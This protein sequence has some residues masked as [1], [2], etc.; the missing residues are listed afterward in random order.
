M[1]RATGRTPPFGDLR[2]QWRKMHCAVLNPYSSDTCPYSTEDCGLAFL[3]AVERSVD[4]ASPVGY[5]R[6]V[7]RSM[8]LDR[9]DNK[10][11]ERERDTTPRPSYEGPVGLHPAEGQ[12]L[13]GADRGPVR[14]GDLLGA[15][16][17]GPRQRPA[18]DGKASAK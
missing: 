8:A 5:F 17:L 13:R 15:L 7:A 14:I 4:K 3:A 6:S 2:Q 11:L 1:F 10:P 9:A 12:G 18:D 16:D